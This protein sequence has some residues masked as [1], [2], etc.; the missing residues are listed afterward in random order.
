MKKCGWWERRTIKGQRWRLRHKN[1]NDINKDQWRKK[2]KEQNEYEEGSKGMN[3]V[4]IRKSTTYSLDTMSFTPLKYIFDIVVQASS[5]WL[6]LF[7]LSSSMLF[8]NPRWRRTPP[9]LP[10]NYRSNFLLKV[11]L[12]GGV[13]QHFEKFQSQSQHSAST[14]LKV[15]KDKLQTVVPSFSSMI[16]DQ[17][18]LPQLQLPS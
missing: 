9:K 14:L 17:N 3:E 7:H 8:F 6:I 16:S 18:I 5:P 1:T 15:Y 4:W 11:F 12:G 13:I 2:M 10:P